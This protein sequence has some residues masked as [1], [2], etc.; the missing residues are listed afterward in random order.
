MSEWPAAATRGVLDPTANAT[1]VSV[2]QYA[3]TI[4]RT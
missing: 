4:C 3:V 2:T 1:G